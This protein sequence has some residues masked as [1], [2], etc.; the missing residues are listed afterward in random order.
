[1]ADYAR[2]GSG[3]ATHFATKDGLTTG[4]ADKVIVGAQFDSEFNAILTAIASTFQSDQTGTGGVATQSEAQGGTVNDAIMTPLRSEEHMATYGLENDGL[5]SQ[6]HA[7]ASTAADGVLGW[8]QS[9]SAGSELILF[10][11]TDGIEFSTTTL[12]LKSALGGAGLQYASGVLALDIN[13]LAADTP[14]MADTIAFEDVGGGD[15]NKCTITV[16]Q[17]LLEANISVNNG[18]WSGTDLAVTNGGTG[19]STSTGSGG[20]VLLA[21]PTITGTLVTTTIT[22]TTLNVVQAGNIRKTGE[23]NYLFHSSASYDNDQNGAITFATTA[24]SGGVT[25]DIH[26]R[27]TA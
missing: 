20:V 24:A 10:T 21:S 27:Y 15:D 16:L 7:I 6:L 2:A 19:S 17:T 25:G 23:G 4:D 1:M 12:R 13:E 11:A 5:V 18:N 3:G 26:F 9:A 8:D 22:N 14:V